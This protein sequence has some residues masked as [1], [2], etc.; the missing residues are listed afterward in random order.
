M[1]NYTPLAEALLD[2][3]LRD[4]EE[5]KNGKSDKDPEPFRH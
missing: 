5:E 1:I 3:I 2:A 4:Q